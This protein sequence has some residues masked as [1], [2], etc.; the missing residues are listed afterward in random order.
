MYFNANC[1]IL[2]S[3]AV[4]ITPKVLPLTAVLKAFAVEVSDRKRFRM[5]NASARTSSLWV[6]RKRNTLDKAV[7]KDQVPG[8]ST[9]L[10]STFPNAPVAGILNA[11]G[12]RK[13]VPGL[14]EVSP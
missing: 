8:P 2:G 5:L 13:L 4:R 9:L 6:S 11:A 12:L 10:R 7:S 3:R 1:M 14:P